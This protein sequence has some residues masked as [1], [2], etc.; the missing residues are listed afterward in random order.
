M[1]PAQVPRQHVEPRTARPCREDRLFAVP[2]HHDDHQHGAAV[3]CRNAGRHCLRQWAHALAR[4]RAGHHH[5]RCRMAVSLRGV[6]QPACTRRPQPSH[7]QFDRRAG[8]GAL[9]RHQMG[10]WHFHCHDLALRLDAAAGSRRRR[11][12]IVADRI[13]VHRR[14]AD[15]IFGAS[16]PRSL[17]QHGAWR[18]R[19]GDEAGMAASHRDDRRRSRNRLCGDR[20]YRQRSARDPW[21]AQRL[22]ADRSA[23]HSGRWRDC[24]LWRAPRP[25][26]MVLSRQA[27]GA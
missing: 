9:P 10:A 22:F 2:R 8:Q 15:R 23:R 14:G 13:H 12:Q 27:R 5:G 20:L 21:P 19:S 4:D 7:G 1:D 24:R 11:P 17:A 18:G 6:L 3:H 25:Y 26:R 16:P